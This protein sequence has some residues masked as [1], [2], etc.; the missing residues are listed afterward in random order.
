MGM[1]LTFVGNVVREPRMASTKTGKIVCN[2]D[3]AV[4]RFWKGADGQKKTLFL[5]MSAWGQTAE[6]CGKNL[7]KGRKIVAYCS[8]MEADAYIGNDNAA[9]A[10]V[11]ATLERFEFASGREDEESM[12]AAPGAPQNRPIPSANAADGFIPVEDEDLPF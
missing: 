3:L 6:S 1:T 5:Q 9:H 12:G 10:Q 4:N 11:K 8:D 2:F 7:S